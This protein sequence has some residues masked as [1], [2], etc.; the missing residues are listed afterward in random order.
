[1][2]NLI[3][4][5]REG[6]AV[7]VDLDTGNDERGMPMPGIR[8]TWKAGADQFAALLAQRISERLHTAL[9]EARREAYNQGW[10]QAKAKGKAGAKCT[11]FPGHL[12]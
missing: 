8:L 7:V 5:S 4:I 11:W 3:R 9:V 2:A 12:P 1:M 10:K 6:D